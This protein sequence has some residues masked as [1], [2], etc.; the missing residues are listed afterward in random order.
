MR[1]SALPTTI[2]FA[3]DGQLQPTGGSHNSIR[4]RLRTALVYTYIE[5]GGSISLERRCLR[6]VS[7]ANSTVS[8]KVVGRTELHTTQILYWFT[9]FCSTVRS[10][11]FVTPARTSLRL[12]S[13]PYMNSEVLFSL[14]KPNLPREQTVSQLLFYEISRAKLSSTSPNFVIII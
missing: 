8:D 2:P 11:I 3:R 4:T 12:S 1:L 14:S 13:Q 10:Y 7:Y 5:R 6:T 9:V